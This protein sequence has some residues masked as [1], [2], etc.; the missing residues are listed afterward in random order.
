MIKLPLRN[1][2]IS[3]CGIILITKDTG[4]NG[5][6]D[7]HAGLKAKYQKLLERLDEPEPQGV[8]DGCLTV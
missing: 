7:C 2:K 3:R 1:Q 5:I 6:C 4:Q 8:I